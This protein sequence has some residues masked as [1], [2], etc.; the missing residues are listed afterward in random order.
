MTVPSF[1]CGIAVLGC[2][3]NTADAEHFA[4]LLDLDA[5]REITV[6]CPGFPEDDLPH[7]DAVVLFTCAFIHAA[8]EESVEA[9]L[10]WV[11]HREAF[12][13]PRQIYVAGCLSQ[14]YADELKKEIPEVDAWV[15]ISD[16]QKLKA[17]L[18]E[19]APRSC[20]AVSSCSS[21][22][23]KRLDNKPYAF[24]KIGDG[25]DHAC[26]FCIIPAIKGRLHSRPSQEILDEAKVL[27]ES[28][29][30]ELNLVAQD[31]TAYGRDLY[32]EYR[33]QHLLADLCAIPGDFWIRCLYCYPGGITEALLEEITAQ[34]KIVPYLDIPLQHTAPKVLKAM[35][36]PAHA[37]NI[38]D[39]I[40]QIREKVPGITLRTTMLIGF[41]GESLT[42][43]RHL[44]R[45]MESMPFEWL[46]AFPY[47]REEGTEATLM[48]KQLRRDTITRRCNE[49]LELQAFITEAF[50]MSRENKT[51]RA[52]IEGYDDERNCW[53]ARSASEAPEVDG[54]IFVESKTPLK[55]GSFIDVRLMRTE[56]YDM[57]ARPA[58]EI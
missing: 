17:L 26:S 18:L 21:G 13:F 36:R 22:S 53:I 14:R 54:V 56:L 6:L 43:H 34:P 10:R 3:K 16:L 45:F 1:Q 29:V 8:K 19:K 47:S 37:L 4:G 35:Q 28:G 20:C 44:L 57:V 30:R 40:C 5:G 33:L 52:L 9:I 51:V 24:L 58:T 50:N 32:A 2:D 25:C 42:D 55:Q 48:K 39:L 41:P 46:G 12:G 7:L 27:I 15:G 38:G 23:R 31:C 49:V 11:N